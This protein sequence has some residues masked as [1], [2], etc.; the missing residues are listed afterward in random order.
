MTVDVPHPLRL[1]MAQA[2]LEKDIATYRAGG[3]PSDLCLSMPKISRNTAT[4]RPERELAVAL[5]TSIFGD[6]GRAARTKFDGLMG[7]MRTKIHEANRL[8]AANGA[9][10]CKIGPKDAIEKAEDTNTHA[11]N[12]DSHA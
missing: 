2:Q 12:A 7:K 10:T 8:K 3:V 5:A 1:A 6:T 9:T 4:E 11:S